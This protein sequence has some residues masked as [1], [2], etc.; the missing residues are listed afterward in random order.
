MSLPFRR[1]VG[2]TTQNNTKHNNWQQKP[3]P[4]RGLA[5][6]QQLTLETIIFVTYAVFT[7]TNKGL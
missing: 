2:K 3:S 1:I 5:E 6:V 7:G 4:G